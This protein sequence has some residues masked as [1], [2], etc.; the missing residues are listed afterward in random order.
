MTSSL[1]PTPPLD[2][3]LP[4]HAPIFLC[5]V[6]QCTL[7]YEGTRGSVDVYTCPEGC[8]AYERDRSTH[9]LWSVSR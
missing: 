6:C 4:E 5:P 2:Q 7:R 3:S 9:R 1:N 8:G